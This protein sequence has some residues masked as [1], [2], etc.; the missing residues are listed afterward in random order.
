MTDKELK[1]SM[2]IAGELAKEICTG[3]PSDTPLSRKWKEDSARLYEEIRKQEHLLE[4]ISFHDSVDT[5]AELER[6]SRRMNLPASRWN[7]RTLYNIG[8]AASFLLLLGVAAARLLWTAGSEESVAQWAASV[9]E[10]PKT[11]LIARDGRPVELAAN[12]LVVKGDRLTAHTLDG[13]RDIAIELHPGNRFNKLSVPAGGEY[14]LTLEDGTVVQVNA[15]S[16]LLFPAHF[17][18]H[19]RQV[20]LR[21]EACFHVSHHPEKP[22][23]VRLGTL[24]VQVT[25]TSFNVKAYEEEEHIAITLTEG[26]VNVREGQKVLAALSP[27]EQFTYHKRTRDYATSAADIPAVTGWTENKFVFHNET[28]GN[29]MNELSR[30]YNVDIHVSKEIRDVRYNGMLSR[31]QPLAEILHILHLTNELD[32]KIYRDERRIDAIEKRNE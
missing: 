25:G 14:R 15:A 19:V 6:V 31:K 26:S 23:N 32:F 16:E 24:N 20:E 13:K 22:F 18:Q 29:I 30:W 4:E 17:T 1:E 3:Q 27:G 2:Q 12:D 28:I 21:G 8:I 5:V 9:P 7:R 10:P 11:S